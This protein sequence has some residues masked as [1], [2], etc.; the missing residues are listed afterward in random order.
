MQIAVLSD[1]H[2]HIGRLR[3]ALEKVTDCDRLL[4]CGDLCSPFIVSELGDRFDG[5]V[6]LVWGNNDGDTYRLTETAAEY[7]SISVHGEFG[8]LEIGGRS[9]AL[10]HFDGIGRRL[11]ESE[12]Y[13]LVCFGHNHRREISEVGETL[14]CN[15]GEVMGELRGE[16]TCARYDTSSGEAAFVPL[17]N[18]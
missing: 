4:C 12:R 10:I 13:D 18:R 15:P 7:A 11:A 9:I 2:D 3:E 6:D 17:G 8:E 5:P 1:I 16:A 14:V